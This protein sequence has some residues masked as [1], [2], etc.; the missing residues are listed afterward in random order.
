MGSEKQAA[1]QEATRVL[2]YI[3]KDELTEDDKNQIVKDSIENFNEHVNPGWLTYRKS[4]STDE[5]FVEWEDSQETFKDTHGREFIDCLGGFGIYTAGHRNPEIVAAVQAQLNRYA[6]HSQELVDPLRG[7]LA[8]LVS[9][10]TPGDLK[11]AFFCNGGAEAIEMA[12]K[13]ARLASGNHYFISTVNGFHGKSLGAVSVTGNGTYRKPYLPIIQGVQHVE[14]GNAQVAEAAI[15]NL[16]AVGETVAHRLPG[17]FWCLYGRSPQPRDRRRSSGPAEPLRVAQPG[18]GG[19]V[20]GISGQTGIDVHAG[21]L[22]VCVFLQRRGR[23]Q[24]DGPEAC[25]A[26]LGQSLFYIHGKRFS[27]QITRGRIG[28][29]Q[30]DLPQTVSSHHS[31]GAAR[32]VRQCAGGRSCHQKSDRRGGD[33]RGHDR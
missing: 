20:K 30:G 5:A 24:R 23:G 11:Y 10:C 26:G 3:L 27:R 16:I 2:Q 18:T 14:F 19:P 1:L 31:R 7:Y 17:R 15:K 25:A 8:K 32:G 21:R 29:G 33:S 28:H 12:L 6:L 4:V 9:M 22:K 13:L